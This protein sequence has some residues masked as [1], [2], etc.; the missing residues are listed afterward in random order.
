M[1]IS[2][3]RMA[4]LLK[5]ER[6]PRSAKYD[7][8]WTLE[9]W[10]G[11]NVLW[12]AEW[13]CE[14]MNLKPGMRVLDLGC[15]KARSSVFLA[16]EFGVQVWA[17]D[18]WIKPTENLEHIRAGGMEDLVFPVYAEAHALPYAEELFDAGRYLAMIRVVARRK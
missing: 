5:N 6:F 3:E 7:P 10:M 14:E 11:P 1:N 2:K 18:L 4:E 13:L 17:A 15:G 8:Q 16:R 12:L 9:G